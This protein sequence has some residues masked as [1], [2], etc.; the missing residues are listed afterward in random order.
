MMNIQFEETVIL[1][2]AAYVDKITGDLIQ[3]FSRVINRTLTTAD[4]SL[5]LEALALDAGLRP[6]VDEEKKREIQT[7]LIYDEK[8][9]TLKYEKKREIQTLLIY[10]EK[11]PTLKYIV[12]NDLTK[13]LNNVAFDSKLGEFVL[14]TYHPSGMT[15]HTDFVLDA[16][17]L[18]ADAKEVKRLIVVADDTFIEKE[19]LPLL[20]K[21]DGKE[22]VTLFSMNPSPTN[23]EAKWEMLGFAILRALGIRSE[24]L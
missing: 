18:V 10:D 20:D 23:K 9:P 16:L 1:L 14:N 12:P 17:R 21:V 2:D 6:V 22:S 7:L 19:V 15:P 13:K 11:Q 4:L 3:Y 24:E 5:L 8:Q